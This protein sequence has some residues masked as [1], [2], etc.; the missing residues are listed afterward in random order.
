MLKYLLINIFQNLNGKLFNEA[1][2]PPNKYFKDINKVY[3]NKKSNIT[4]IFT[5]INEYGS[6]KFIL[7]NDK[8]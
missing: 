7:P 6:I 3:K 5:I 2:I 8:I 4:K 1:K